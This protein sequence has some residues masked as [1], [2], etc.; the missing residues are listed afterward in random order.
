MQKTANIGKQIYLH[1][2]VTNKYITCTYIIQTHHAFI[3][4]SHQHVQIPIYIYKHLLI[5]I[6]IHYTLIKLIYRHRTQT[7]KFCIVSFNF[8]HGLKYGDWNIYA[9]KFMHE[10]VRGRAC[11]SVCAG[12]CECVCKSTCV[13][14]SASAII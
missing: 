8:F 4:Y 10:S 13:S 7:I 6:R 12:L 11:V 3:L 2:C 9:C 14:V 5:Y 1:P